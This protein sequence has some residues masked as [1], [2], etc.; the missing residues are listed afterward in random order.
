MRRVQTLLPRSCLRA[1]AVAVMAV[2]GVT[3]QCGAF[4]ESYG[5]LDHYELCDTHGEFVS[6]RSIAVDP[7]GNI[8]V[9]DRSGTIWHLSPSGNLRGS[10]STGPAGEF[11]FPVLANGPAGTV[12]VA[13]QSTP[14]QLVKYA[15]DGRRF[16]LLRRYPTVEG[17]YTTI[18]G[19]RDPV[20][21]VASTQRGLFVLDEAEG[22]VNIAEADG[23]F[24][25]RTDVPGRAVGIA[26]VP[27]ALAVAS[28]TDLAQ[29]D[30]VSIF[31]GSR[32]TY[33][34]GFNTSEFTIGI[35]GGYDGTIWALAN[36]NASDPGV[37]G[38]EHFSLSGT[39]LGAVPISGALYALDTA[40]DG[41]VWIARADGILRIGP[42]G[43]TVP[44]DAYGHSV[45][46]APKVG[47]TFTKVQDIASTHHL[48]LVSWCN[49]RCT[50]ALTGTLTI[51]SAR[52]TFRLKAPTRRAAARA[53]VSMPLALTR[54]AVA[55][56][57]RAVSHHHTATLRLTMTA[58]DAA[59]TRTNQAFTLTLK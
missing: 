50:L 58:T 19:I 6:I 14:V 32:L 54:G 17:T 39:R 8:Y 46:G 21:I 37:H 28:T 1:A 20:G 44:P 30:V 42:H 47:H 45:C 16:T 51:P 26:V 11:R 38:L 55:A 18:L 24:I 25:S 10:M 36:A 52:A 35:G 5:M 2:A 27:G 57:Y 15:V 13:D 59:G 41:S 48:T 9:A 34:F 33:A 29:P 40:T 23:A 53:R 31:G 4:A 43:Q 56:L 12:Y 49:E 7:A 22:I 3:A